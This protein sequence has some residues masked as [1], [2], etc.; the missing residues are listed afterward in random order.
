M[1]SR[2]IH[3][4]PPPELVE[5]D[6]EIAVLREAVRDLGRGRGGVVV[7]D[8]G[9]GMG[10]TAL[11]REAR[12]E[13]A[14]VGVRVLSA[15]GAELERDFAFGVVR[16]L[17]EPALP[18]DPDERRALLTG[19]ASATELILGDHA[20]AGDGLPGSLFTLL[21]GAYWALVT[22]AER[23]PLVVVADDAQWA[24]PP[25]LRFL[26]F[27]ARRL[28]SVA[29]LLVVAT[30]GGEHDDGGLL[31]DLLAVEG[32]AHLRLRGLSA[33][34]VARLVR[35]HL[36][37]ADDELCAACHLTTAGNPL[38]V[39]ELVRVLQEDGTRPGADGAAAVAAAG[40]DAVRRYVAA[41]LRRQSAEVRQVAR[42]VAVLGDDTTLPLVAAH[43]G[44]DVASAA[45]C[46]EHLV[47]HGVLVSADP[48]AFVHV[49]VRDVVLSLVPLAERGDEHDR[50][51]R[52][53]AEAGSPAARV[54]SHVLRTTP[55][56]RG[57]RVA[58][59]TGAADEAWRRGSPEGA[60]TY[61]ARARLEPPP[62]QARS[63]VSRLLGNCEVHRLSTAA[64]DTYLR[65]AVQLAGTPEQRARCWYS[66]ARFRHSCGRGDAALE[67]L[68]H[69]ADRLPPDASP[70]LVRDLLSEL[71]GVARAELSA[72]PELLTRLAVFRATAREGDP[73]LAAHLSVEAVF[74]GERA[75]V[76]VALAR[77]ALDGDRL[78][79]ERSAIW[80]AVSTLLVAHHLVE[81]EQRVLRAL[82][83]AVERG[84]LSAIG[85]VRGYLARIALL[86]GDLPAAEE[87]ALLGARAVPRPNVGLPALDAA[88]VR[89]LVERGRL[90]QARAVLRDGELADG[91]PPRNSLHL[92][93]LEARMAL[94][95]AR[96][97]D[98]AVL[99]DAATCAALHE[100]W[101][102]TGLWD[103]PWRLHASA[104]HLR[105]GR[106]ERAAALAAEE[107]RL[108]RAFGA[109]GQVARALRAVAVAG[110]EGDGGHL[111]EAV[112]LLRAGPA[113]LELAHALADLGEARRRGGDR[114]GARTALREAA[115]V[116]VGCG[117]EA[118]ADRLRA[119]LA[120]GGGRPPRIEVTGV[121][122]LTPSERRV[123][124]LAADALTNRQIAENLFVTEKTVETHLGRA[125]RKLGVRSRTQLAVRM[126]TR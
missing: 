114:A 106:R 74:T 5:R 4:G 82:R 3:A 47:R 63:E 79:P 2:S 66:L 68:T 8:A 67:L 75:D 49:V 10:K 86:R 1:R 35:R 96:G 107:L 125:F 95:A 84:Q 25:S 45:A 121:A 73:V 23:G 13:A 109:P 85:V 20:P 119:G 26:G 37:A 110:S 11:L 39:R 71:L 76:A 28:D 118:L 33:T 38:F 94:S 48:P 54:A 104:A 57:D 102:V 6:A 53:L 27:L 78:A 52:V 105:S 124:E 31:D 77:A 91:A 90:E 44:V 29:V 16:Q 111:A 32:C 55:A 122:A 92:W 80:S 116:A 50:A 89:L 103:V 40:P 69:A 100:R 14:A 123:A 60:A 18:G 56:G 120:A 61:L 19:A 115:E 64:A 21:N 7:V 83:D 70:A 36:D 12:D 59:L 24:D 108:A 65:E 43:A 101:G 30:R 62:P 42:A 112:A 117:A 51:A 99:A 17:L 22:L 81:A 34:G 41:R 126:A 87:H 15:R 93:L 113:R 58:L 98:E 97:D 88:R 72:R 46:A 9:A